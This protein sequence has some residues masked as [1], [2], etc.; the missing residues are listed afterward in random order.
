MAAQLAIATAILFAAGSVTAKKGLSRMTVVAGLLVSLL[1]TGLVTLV[2]A[3]IDSPDSWPVMP[4]VMFAASG[5]LGDGVGRVAFL[6]A[7]HRL[8]PSTAVPIQTATYPTLTVLLGVVA[9]SESVSA[10]QLLG[11]AA[12]VLGVWTLASGG[13]PRAERS[14]LQ[15]HRGALVLPVL[16][17]ASFGLADVFRKHGLEDLPSPAFGATVAALTALISWTAAIGSAAQL[18]RQVRLGDGTGW[19]ALSGVLQGLGLLTLFGALDEG[20]VSLVGPI[21]AS[22]PLVVVV[23][24][25]F[26]LRELEALT[27]AVVL[28]ALATMV[29]VI[30]VA[31][32]WPA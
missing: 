30:L 14:I 2:A 29:G 24:S 28:G 22:Q 19:L 11:V 27:R 1:M 25:A 31:S 9:L 3:V 8:G 15:S 5:L 18:R 12:V 17:G 23:L 26:L 13:S 32:T 7:V 10:V 21:V 20:D 16:A 6:S 4:I